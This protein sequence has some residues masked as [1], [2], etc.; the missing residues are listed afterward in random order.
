MRQSPHRPPD[1]SNEKRVRGTKHATDLLYQTLESEMAAAR[2]YVTA[3]ASVQNAVL[4]TEWEQHLA[5]TKQHIEIVRQLL[6]DRGLD[7][8]RESVSRQV[9]RHIGNAL[10]DAIQIA[11]RSRTTD[12][13]EIVAAECVL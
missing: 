6:A 2:V 13:A 7:P 4:R 9:V 1:E 8:H 5:Q 3:L 11:L 10:V 12:A